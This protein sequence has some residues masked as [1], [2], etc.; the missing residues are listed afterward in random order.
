[1]SS[2]PIAELYEELVELVSDLLAKGD[3]EGLRQELSQ[4][5]P[6]E[7]AMVM[8]SLP[9]HNRPRIWAVLAPDVQAE[10][11]LHLGD[12]AR[13]SLIEELPPE[14]LVTTGQTMDVDALVEVVDELPADVSETIV[15][16]LDEQDKQRLN[17][18]LS[19]AEGTAGRLMHTD[20]RTVRPDITVDAALRYL[21]RFGLTS[22]TD[23][24]MVVDRDDKYIGKLYFTTL[25]TAQ[26][27][28]TVEEIMDTT[29]TAIPAEMPERDVAI[30]F[31]QRELVSVPVVDSDS[32]L[33]GRIG[34]SD[35]VNIIHQEADHAL[36][37]MAGLEEEEDLFA[38]ILPSARRRAFWLGINLITAFLAAWVIGLFEA[39]LD[40]VVA[41]AVLMPIVAS[42]GGIG[43]SQ[44]LTLT[45][46]GL[47]LGQIGSAN[48]RW[49]AFKELAIGFLNGLLWAIVV[50]VVAVLWFS[51]LRIGAI[52]AAAVIIN[53]I[54]AALSGLFIPLILDRF[55]IDP[56]LSGAVVLT[57]VTDVVGFMSFL[58]LGTIF[59]L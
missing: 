53:M 57:T 19:Y 9:A 1:M 58:G 45:I 6:A 46:R 29:A 51:D 11:L 8:E 17:T 5:Y 22:Q 4:R 20:L 30:M 43:G 26:P 40:K 35:V 25:V 47:A 41:L 52:I 42:M 55:G 14:A 38:P 16:A 33:V 15:A 24:M 3:D 2:L 31:D 48:S 34:V 59:L 49:L 18:H 27:D 7:I 12:I 21:R 37:H 28:Q 13:V 10:V 54:A 44:T 39:T 56:A 23:S 36:M 50:A 32:R